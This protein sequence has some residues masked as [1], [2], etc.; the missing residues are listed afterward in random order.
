MKK[1]KKNNNNWKLIS[2]EIL[3]IIE[4]FL[5]FPLVSLDQ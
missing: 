1:K 3:A 5:K 4:Y 2:M